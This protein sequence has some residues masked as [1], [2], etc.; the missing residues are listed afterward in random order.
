MEQQEDRHLATQVAVGWALFFLV[1]VFSLSTAILFSIFENNGFKKLLEDPG[2]GAAQ[3]LLYV[4]LVVSLMPIYVFIV[5]RSKSSV[6]RWPSLLLACAIFILGALH[7]WG[8]W[9]AGERATFS[10]NI[11][12]FMADGAALW[13][14][15][16]SFA[17]ARRSAS[18]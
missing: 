6:W 17:W 12:D 13:L 5:G 18:A 10:S 16:S 3:V 14:V 9:S 2:P 7:H 11:I 4:F 15:F 1:K 8:H